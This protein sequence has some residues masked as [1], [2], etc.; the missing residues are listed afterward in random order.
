MKNK[1]LIFKN[2]NFLK[3][4]MADF[5]SEM[6]NSAR[7]IAIPLFIFLST[8][9]YM[10][11]TLTA[12]LTTLPVIILSPLAGK[13]ADKYNKKFVMSFSDLVRGILDIIL[14]FSTSNI[15]LV[16]GVNFF[17][18]VANVFFNPAAKSMIP[19]IVDKDNL[20]DANSVFSFL[21]NS[22][23]LLGPI[24]GSFLG[25]KIAIVFDAITFI[26]SSI[27][28]IMIKYENKDTNE[29]GN[30][31]P[32]KLGVRELL[33][34]LKDNTQLETVVFMTF[35][36]SLAFSMVP[37][38]MPGYVTSTL[39]ALNKTYGIIL[40]TMTLGGI[41]GSLINTYINERLTEEIIFIVSYGLYGFIYGALLIFKVKYVVIMLF[42]M[43]GITMPIMGIASVTIEQ[44]LIDKRIMGRFFGIVASIQ[45][46]LA[47]LGKFISGAI[48]KYA[49]CLGV[50]LL[51]FLLLSIGTVIGVS[52]V[53]VLNNSS[54][55]D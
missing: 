53:R 14:I 38:I 11:M 23:Y 9:S 29:E 3:F 32:K 47:L 8:K 18:S 15:Y 44:K 34:L 37:V 45:A 52:K 51:A 35:I 13:F 50:F 16:M 6:G 41:I 48:A 28:I 26:V 4:T 24:L 55:S 22:C 5:I 49:G 21:G 12:A 36:L 10:M 7:V 1:F 19:I 46:L 30:I 31:M 27:L 20:N 40:S 43:Q 2:R 33:T 42:F 54:L 17:M 25:F 39:G